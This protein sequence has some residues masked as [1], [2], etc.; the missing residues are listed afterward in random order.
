MRL[1]FGLD[2]QQKQVQKLAPRMIQSM[3]ILQLPVMAL[4]ER[5]D[6]ALSDNPVLEIAADVDD[7]GEE[8]AAE[9]E[10]GREKP[11][12]EK[13]LV[14]KEDNNNAEDFERLLQMDQEF[15][16]T[17]D[18]T[19]RKSSGQRE[20]DSDRQHDAIANL[21]E[22]SESLNDYLINQLSEW[23]LEPEMEEMCVR[24]IS[25]LD[26]KDGGYLKVELR[27]LLPPDATP[28][29]L[30]LA[31]RALDVV[32]QLDPP[33]IAARDLKECLLLQI[34][35]DMPHYEAVRRVI[36]HH[37][38]DLRENRLPLI[39]KATGMTLEQVK[40]V[41]D[42]IRELNPR[43]A[44]AFVETYVPT[45][46]PDVAVEKTDDGEYKVTL[47][48]DRTPTLHISEYYRQRLMSETASAE[49]KEF[50]RRKINA[51]QWLI[52]SIEQR[53][54]TV[55]KVAQEIVNHQKRFLDDGPEFIEPLKM[56]QIAERVGVHVTTVSRAVDEKYIQT[57]RGILPLKRFFVGGTKSDDG[58]E[59]AWD[60]VRIKLTEVVEKE[61]K[62]HPLSDDE[63]VK[64]FEKQGLHVARRTITKYRQ[65]MDIPSSRQ[66]RDW[67]G[68]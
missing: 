17:F 21:Q 65:K 1:S 29:Q 54:A 61:D 26:P 13:E 64:E 62:K 55:T 24:I 32:H 47:L 41:W 63:I 31:K 27:D 56:Q 35:T 20:E 57:P 43:P 58:E 59:I 18:E 52:E 49:E 30:S 16:D 67:S 44:S 36:T 22:K 34:N 5:I 50:I 23:E 53:R 6:Q 8:A 19:H 3:E 40:I 37:L 66:R 51:A 38:E 45:V 14:V 7:G 25:T 9:V 42:Q 2:L 28:A 48:D 46:T 10:E 60:I 33:G 12:G 39:V 11:E 68:K 4:Q 15:P